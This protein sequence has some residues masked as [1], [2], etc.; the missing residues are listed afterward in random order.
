MTALHDFCQRQGIPP[1]HFEAIALRRALYPHARMLRGILGIVRADF[2][3]I[4][5]E[6]VRAAGSTTSS[7]EFRLEELEFHSHPENS[8]LLRR[9]MLL[10]VSTRRLHQLLFPSRRRTNAS[11]G[12]PSP[13][14]LSAD[15]NRP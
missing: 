2:F 15:S 11:L 12:G 14:A 9:R 3:S 5:R 6:F 13:G 8:S 1:E 10:R 4:D 7:R